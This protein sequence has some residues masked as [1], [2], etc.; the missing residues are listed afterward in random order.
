MCYM[1]AIVALSKVI[2]FP[3]AYYTPTSKAFF[4]SALVARY[5]RWL[6]TDIQHQSISDLV[7]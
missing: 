1:V 2:Q 7:P 4:S 3:R 5:I 6:A